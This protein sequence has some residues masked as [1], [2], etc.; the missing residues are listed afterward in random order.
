MR[1][2]VRTG[3]GVTLAPANI[4]ENESL[5]DSPAVVPLEEQVFY[6]ASMQLL[7]KS[8]RNLHE[9]VETI[10]TNLASRMKAFTPI[11]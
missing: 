10:A 9:T 1:L 2:F 4:C 3:L 11:V 6:A 5:Q 8:G 7:V